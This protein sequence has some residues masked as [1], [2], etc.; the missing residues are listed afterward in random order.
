VR[1]HIKSVAAVTCVL[2]LAACAQ[3]GAEA[4]ANV[5]TEGQVNTRQKAEVVNILAVMP[6]KIQVS[7]AQNQR[8]A[9]IAGALIGAAAGAGLG[10]GLGHYQPVAAGTVG[11]VG[12]GT[13]GAMA[14]SLVPGQV[15]VDG[16]SI[17][18][19]DHGS[20]FSSAQVGRMC[21]YVP[22]KAVVISTSPTETRIQPNASCP[23]A[24]KKA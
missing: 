5:Y 19:V 18:Y 21:E 17:T 2:S 11:A 1:K 7:N 23:P 12:G 6:A 13:V 16:V 24:P 14:G 4:G 20:T 8:T 3:P 10:A 9:Q 22:G 15:L